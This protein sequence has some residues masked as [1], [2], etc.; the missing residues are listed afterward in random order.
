MIENKNSNEHFFVIC[1]DKSQSVKKAIKSG[2]APWQ[3]HGDGYPNFR[4]KSFPI[5][6]NYRNSRQ[7]NEYIRRFTDGALKFAEEARI[8]INQDADIFL[9]GKSFRD[10]VEPQYIQIPSKYPDSDSEAIKIVNQIEDIH[11]N[12]HIPYD[13]I[14]VICY[15]RQYRFAYRG[16]ERDYKPISKLVSYLRDMDIPYSLLNSSSDEY[17]VSYSNITGVPIVTMESS[18]GLDFKAVI[19]C[20]LFPLGL[21]DHTKNEKYL[22]E[23][24]QLEETVNAYNKNINILYMA[25]A[26]AKDILRIITSEEPDDSVYIK[27][28]YN[29][30]NQG[31]L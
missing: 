31:E 14:A 21:H 29:A 23:N 28:L 15:N 9:R 30:F 7:I 3:G 17:A 22:I 8:P 5:E 26:R 18:L 1:G 25:C 19:I 20:G 11:N 10:G 12:Y 2:K 6:I 4:G 16:G 24:R 27:L 13:S